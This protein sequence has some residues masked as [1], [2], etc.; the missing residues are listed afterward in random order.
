MWQALL[1]VPLLACLPAFESTGAGA[2]QDNDSDPLIHRVH[3]KFSAVRNISKRDVACPQ[4][5]YQSGENCC[6]R[7]EPGYVKVNDCTASTKTICKKCEEGKEYMD[8]SN[9]H[10][11]CFRCSSCDTEYGLEVDKPCNSSQN[12]RCRCKRGFYCNS[13][14]PCPHCDPC[15]KCEDGIVVEECTQTSDT[16]CER[17]WSKKVPKKQIK[18]EQKPMVSIISQMNAFRNI[19]F[20][21]IDLTPHISDIAEQ[22]TSEQVLKFVR[23]QGLSNPT[24]DKINSDYAREAS[25]RKIK[26]LETWYQ[27]KGIKGAY[28]TLVRSLRDLKERVLADKIVQ[29]MAPHIQ[30]DASAYQNIN[31]VT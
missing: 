14:E 3:N 1:L 26:L 16:I 2:R 29:N 10:S 25:E 27:E 15:T 31:V 13:S 30:N 28:G 11:K 9:Y 18:D 19:N 5:K 12:V 7:C 21:D 17:K 24:I 6:D 23:K 22:M 8:F 4:G 20:L